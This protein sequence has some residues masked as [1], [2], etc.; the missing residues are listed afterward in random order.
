MTRPR[1]LKIPVLPPDM[2]MDSARRVGEAY[3]LV[4]LFCR[5][6]TNAGMKVSRIERS[7]ALDA[8]ASFLGEIGGTVNRTVRVGFEKGHF[9][10]DELARMSVDHVE[11]IP[12]EAALETVFDLDV[13]ITGVDAGIAETGSLVTASGPECPRSLSLIPPVHIAI[14]PVSMLIPDLVDLYGELHP[15]SLPAALTL[16]TGPSKTADIDGILITG[17]HGPGQVRVFL[18]TGA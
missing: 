4:D 2:V 15:N 1:Q 8:I 14:V 13:G 7:N 3:D 17:V 16:I 11:L 6:A 10:S 9:W 18:V 12:A 5:Q